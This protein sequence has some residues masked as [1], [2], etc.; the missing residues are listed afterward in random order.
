MPIKETKTKSISIRLTQTE[1]NAIN[2]LAENDER[3]VSEY[4]RLII[5]RTI[6]ENTENER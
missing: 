5:K 2:A 3:T 1:Y 4:I 6:K